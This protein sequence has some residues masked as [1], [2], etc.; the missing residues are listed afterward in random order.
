MIYKPHLLNI[1]YKNL[2]LLLRDFFGL[3]L[4]LQILN[5]VIIYVEDFFLNIVLVLGCNGV[6]IICRNPL[7]YKLCIIAFVDVLAIVA[8]FLSFE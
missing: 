1:A 4:S 7:K 5:D 8:V 2:Q 6:Q 3:I